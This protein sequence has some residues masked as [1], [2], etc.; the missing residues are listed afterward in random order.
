MIFGTDIDVKYVSFEYCSYYFFTCS[1]LVPITQ[2]TKI[3]KNVLDVFIYLANIP[4]HSGD[5]Q[6]RDK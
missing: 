2:Y 3:N 5:F 6:E 1:N 4:I